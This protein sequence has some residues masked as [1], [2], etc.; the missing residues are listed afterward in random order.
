MKIFVLILSIAFLVS[1]RSTK[2]IQTAI[3]K[4]D[5]TITTVKVPVQPASNDSV[6][7]IQNLLNKIDSNRINFQTFTAKVNIDYRGSDGKNYNVNANVRMYKD[8]AIWISAN[9]ILGI[10]VLRLFITKDSMKLLDKYNKLYTAR[11]IDYLQEATTLPL[12]LNT[13]Q[14]V[15]IG[16]PVLLNSNIVSYTTTA[17]QISLMSLGSL[18]KNLLTLDREYFTLL[19]SKLD[20]IDVSRN[21]TAD[22]TYSNYEN[23]KGPFFSTKRRIVV[24]EKTR[25]D[26]KLDFRQYDFNQAVSFPFPIPKNYNRD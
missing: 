22:L 4:K 9:A 10:E 23:K 18:F 15:I 3:T 17:D 7:F 12:D 11:S 24:A 21:R 1:C 8:S 2:K 19:H 20:D 26:V 5:T 6:S 14:D 25:L 16:N 13:L